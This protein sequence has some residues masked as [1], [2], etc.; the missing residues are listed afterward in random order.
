MK[1]RHLPAAFLHS[2]SFVFRHS[3]AMMAHTFT[4]TSL[5]SMLGLEAQ[6]IVFERYRKVRR[7]ERADVE[8]G[9]EA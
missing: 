2:P 6:R 5:R 8:V 7:R 9:D 3:R 4:G 1:L